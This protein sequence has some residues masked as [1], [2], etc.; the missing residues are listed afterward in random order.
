MKDDMALKTTGTCCIQLA[1]W[2]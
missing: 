1:I 2:P